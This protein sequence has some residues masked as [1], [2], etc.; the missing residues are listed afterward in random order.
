MGTIKRVVSGMWEL[1]PFEG[2]K[3]ALVKRGWSSHCFHCGDRSGSENAHTLK[4]NSSWSP[5]PLLRC[6][7]A[8]L[9][10]PDLSSI[11]ESVRVQCIPKEGIISWQHR[12]NIDITVLVHNNQ[13]YADQRAGE[14]TS[15]R[16][17]PRRPTEALHWHLSTMAVAV[18]LHAGFVGR[19]T[20]IGRHLIQLWC[21]PSIIEVFPG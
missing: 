20:S 7:G 14:P 6:N 8:K 12:R 13:V 9:A 19:V 18:A 17:L 1:P 10:N 16:D 3:Q 15:D 2:V 5:R 11:A 21:K 4:A